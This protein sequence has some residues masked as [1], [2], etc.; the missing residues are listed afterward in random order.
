MSE[1]VRLLA[2][3]TCAV[4]DD[5][6]WPTAGHENGDRE[7]RLRHA[8]ERVTREDQ[9]YAASVLAAYRELVRCPEAKR[10]AIVRRLREARAMES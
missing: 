4:F 5:M 3:N 7:W 10:R 1:P 2:N 8:P 9:L 6:T